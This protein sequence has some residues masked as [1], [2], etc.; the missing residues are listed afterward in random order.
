MQLRMQ[1]RRH[2]LWQAGHGL[3]LREGRLPQ[4]GGA[5]EVAQQQSPAVWADAGNVGEQRGELG[6]AAHFA[7]RGD[8]KAMCFRVREKNRRLVLS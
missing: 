1:A 5:A 4:P 3:Q 6:P 2:P 7:V 8:R